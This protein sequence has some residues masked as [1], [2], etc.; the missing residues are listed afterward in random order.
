MTTEQI[1]TEISGKLTDVLD[2]LDLLLGTVGKG[3]A[4]LQTPA[5]DFGVMAR[6]SFGEMLLALLA[7]GLIGIKLIHML[8]DVIAPR[9]WW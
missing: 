7:I 1:L 6:I 8:Y 9:G 5:G 2:K 4:W 3:W